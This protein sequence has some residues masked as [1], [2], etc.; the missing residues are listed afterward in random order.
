M[1]FTKLEKALLQKGLVN[2]EQL[3]D[4][5]K[6]SHGSKRPVQDELVEMEYIKEDALLEAI[7]ELN[8]HAQV[9]NLETTEISNDVAQKVPY[10]LTQKYCIIPVT[11]EKGY[12]ALAMSNPGDVMAIGDVEAVTKMMVRPLLATRSSIMQAIKNIYNLDETVY[13][14]YK[15]LGID[16]NVEIVGKESDSAQSINL[17]DM[18]ND[19]KMAPVIKLVNLIIGDAI[20]TRAS[21]IHLEPRANDVD[22]R[23]RIDGMLKSVMT[24]PK[25]L[26]PAVISRIKILSDLDIAERRK[27]Q[28]GGARVKY[29]NRHIDLRISI[30]PTFSGEKIVIRILDAI[31]GRISIENIGFSKTELETYR[32]FL[33]RR[34]GM[35]LVTGPTGSGKTTTLYG[36]LSY[37]ND[38]RKNITSIENPVEYQVEGINQIQIN[39][40]A[41]V[42]F[43]SS[44][45]S[46]LRQDPNVIFV[47]EIR[48]LET[49]QIALQAAQTGHLV[50]STLHTMSTVSSITRLVD[51]GIERYLVASS[52]VGIV[53]QR[54]LRLIC[55]KCKTRVEP[56]T[57][58]INELDL[59]IPSGTE[60]YKG[61][62]CENCN[63]TGYYGRTA[64]FEILN[65]NDDIRDLIT[66]GATES[67]IL[68]VARKN[69]MNTLS[70]A[71]MQKVFEGTTALEEAAEIGNI[72]RNFSAAPEDKGNG[73]T[74]ILIVDD[75][76]LVRKMVKASL[77]KEPFHIVEAVNGEEGIEK[78][79]QLAPQLIIMD[80]MMPGIDGITVCR[81]LKSNLQT[82]HI[83]LLMF[84]AKSDDESE[85]EGLEAGADDYITKPVTPKKI[86]ARVNKLLGRTPVP[87]AS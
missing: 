49:A 80:I 46:I 74:T 48:D 85:V 47:G 39:P 63:Y 40:L 58:L 69:G 7:A 42:T 71:A 6:K 75:D 30:I 38:G 84:T 77:S 82:G 44:L 79:H 87:V 68:A 73:L 33:H 24:F 10:D 43:A 20:R 59:E 86:L 13:D 67:E 23:Y 3:L 45:R 27:P 83:P 60:F 64:F 66:K 51:I 9:V 61:T 4:A 14:L 28:D 18:S 76:S 72:R 31:R 52:L 56:D 29:E 11:I 32:S 37:L 8:P 78:A 53:A 22:L 12:I 36:S 35:L 50:L 41:G 26:H 81:K 5:K 2:E 25:R 62:G 55:P 70:M 15:N 1:S 17:R 54:L 34:Q 65:A 57:A 21:D 19:A 16:A